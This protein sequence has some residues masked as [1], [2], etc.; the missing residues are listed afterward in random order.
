[1]E[2]E[3]NEEKARL[4]SEIRGKDEI[5]NQMKG[6]RDQMFSEVKLHFLRGIFIQ[7]F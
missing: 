6:E 2:K 5:L 7:S 4:F 3:R 1:M